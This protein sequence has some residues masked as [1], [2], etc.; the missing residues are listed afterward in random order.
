MKMSPCPLSSAVDQNTGGTM[1]A[2][3]LVVC[4]IMLILLAGCS[5]SKESYEKRFKEKFKKS[6]VKS[7]TESAAKKGLKENVAKSK[8]ECVA[9]FLTDKYSS[10]ELMKLTA[11]ELPESKKIIDEAVNSCK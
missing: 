5:K 7:C 9:S 1:T 8:C 6:F 10:V 11:T 2:R 3:I 4:G